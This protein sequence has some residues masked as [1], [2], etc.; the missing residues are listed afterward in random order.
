MSIPGGIRVKLT[1][2]LLGIVGGALLAAYAIVIPSL[3]ARLV[4]A[5]L[6]Q[7]QSDAEAL[8]VNYALNLSS[9]S[10]TSWARRRS[11]RTHGSSS[12]MSPTRLATTC[13]ALC[14]DSSPVGRY[15]DRE[16]SRR[17]QGGKGCRRRESQDR[18]RGA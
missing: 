8:A 15:R 10:R 17:P 4:N 13:F 11:S 14:A 5:K 7:L 9:A 16:R 18:A 12:S 1:L 2:A 6:D 3:E